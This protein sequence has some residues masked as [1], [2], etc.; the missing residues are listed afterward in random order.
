MPIRIDDVAGLPEALGA[1]TKNA[2]EVDFSKNDYDGLQYKPVQLGGELELE[3]ERLR[4]RLAALERKA[5]LREETETCLVCNRAIK[6]K[7]KAQP[8]LCEKHFIEWP[9]C[10]E[11]GASGYNGLVKTVRR[12]SLV[13]RCSSGSLRTGPANT[14]SK[15]S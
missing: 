15:G 14:K 11:C 8:L 6:R 9:K 7:H 1:L 13:R 3:L 12:H 10:P 5:E 4:F 2:G